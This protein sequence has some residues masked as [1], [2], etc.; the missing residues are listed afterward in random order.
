MEKELSPVKANLNDLI[1]VTIRTSSPV[2][3]DTY[4]TLKANGGAILIDETSHLT[5]AACMIQ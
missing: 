5:V 3:I 2:A 1:K 4:K